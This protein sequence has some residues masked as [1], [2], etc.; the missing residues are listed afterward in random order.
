MEDA[1]QKADLTKALDRFK[2]EIGAL[3]KQASDLRVRFDK[4]PENLPGMDTL[5]DDVHAIEEVL[6]VEDGRAKW[7]SSRLDKAFA[8]GKKQEIEA[9]KIAIPP[10]N[11]GI[12]QVIV[13]VSHQLLPIER[14]AAQRRFYD[15]LDA[16]RRP[17]IPE[18]GS[19]QVGRK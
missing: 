11:S 6:G 2:T 13:R 7:L 16:R 18:R 5:R 9:V 19:P 15:A 3:Q 14:L 4:L 12:E 8:S 17:D 1:R 10:G